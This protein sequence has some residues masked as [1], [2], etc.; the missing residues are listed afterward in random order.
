MSTVAERTRREREGQRL[1]E[2]VI[3]EGMLDRVAALLLENTD[4][5]ERISPGRRSTIPPP[6][7]TKGRGDGT[8]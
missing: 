6:R 3:D 5:P 7:A 8:P 2:H 1:P 4:G